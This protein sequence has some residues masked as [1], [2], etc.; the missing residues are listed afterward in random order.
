MSIGVPKRSMNSVRRECGVAAPPHSGRRKAAM[1]PAVTAGWLSRSYTIGG[2]NVTR[3]T[4]SSRNQS[5]K[6][7][8]STR[9][10]QMQVVFLSHANSGP[11][12]MR[13]SSVNGNKTPW[14][15]SRGPGSVSRAAA[16]CQSMLCWLCTAPFGNPV[17]PEVYEIAAGACGSI[18][19]R[20]G[21]ARLR[22]CD[23]VGPVT[24]AVVR[25]DDEHAARRRRRAYREST[26][27]VMKSVASLSASM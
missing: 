26:G 24:G 7:S 8:A 11:S 14:R 12:T 2:A 6:P 20:G 21:I 19:G 1:S 15:S 27:V 22:R 16:P 13:L 23:E 10:M 5:R 4:P 9:S 3:V 18:C 25:I 17:V